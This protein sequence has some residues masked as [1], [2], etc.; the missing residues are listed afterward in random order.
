MTKLIRFIFFSLLATIGL[1]FCTTFIIFL[2]IN[3]NTY[4]SQLTQYISERTGHQLQIKGNISWSAFPFMAIK[5]R[6][7]EFIG[8][9]LPMQPTIQ[10]DE[11]LIQAQF[12]SL[13][14]GN[15]VPSKLYLQ[16]LEV[17]VQE[18]LPHTTLQ[19]TEI[20]ANIKQPIG[21]LL[22]LL[23]MNEMHIKNG[24]LSIQ[25]KAHK[26]TWVLH[27]LLI[28][29]NIKPFSKQHNITLTGMLTN[30]ETN[31]NILLDIK[32]NWDLNQAIQ[33]IEISNLQAK[34]DSNFDVNFVLKSDMIIE[35][36]SRPIAKGELIFETLPPRNH[37]SSIH[38]K[39]QAKTKF[40][41][42]NKHFLLENFTAKVDNNL[43]L[44]GQVKSNIS[45]M[46]YTPLPS[47]FS[48]D[49]PLPTDFLN[50]IILNAQFSGS[51]KD[52]STSK[53]SVTVD[54]KD[55]IIKAP[56]TFTTGEGN[57]HGKFVLQAIKNTMPEAS[58]FMSA[59]N[60][61]IEPLLQTIGVPKVI[62]GNT[63]LVA[64]CSTS[65]HSVLEMFNK[66]TGEGKL[67]IK[68]GKWY[69]I[70]VEK[71]FVIINK[72]LQDMLP[73]VKN[74]ADNKMLNL[75]NQ[76]ARIQEPMNTP[77]DRLYTTLSLNHGIIETPDFSITHPKYKIL[78]KGTY[79][80]KS[81]LLHYNANAYIFELHE[82]KNP[83]TAYFIQHNPL[84]IQITGPIQNPI[85]HPDIAG[86]LKKAIN[87]DAQNTFKSFL[88][89]KEADNIS[90][91]NVKNNL[92][93]TVPFE[94]LFN[95]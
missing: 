54:T 50:N 57:S 17:S 66:L 81:N 59:E 69:G 26:T 29:N 74:Q 80:V 67:E 52:R 71:L 51:Y 90:S 45:K 35:N 94:N 43:L 73:I 30:P 15:F 5:A 37:L 62:M 82:N 53:F 87:T 32:A 86:Y 55:G 88:L 21:L 64:T 36:Q 9:E 3:P 2:C 27:N 56:F 92:K 41:Y 25:N 78:A 63:A 89:E 76:S 40:T 28:D 22:A 91:S 68:A 70:D 11:M 18:A 65:G 24:S 72:S 75:L 93:K 4:S 1:L 38:K 60:F 33:K 42:Q 83:S 10:L 84:P 58:L 14:K 44:Q 39:I 19:P 46:L 13:L 77:F 47:S 23:Q 7:I 85:F 20:L 31:K 8:A 95:D 49:T 12:S 48:I 16:G 6:D 61:D 79:Q 34:F